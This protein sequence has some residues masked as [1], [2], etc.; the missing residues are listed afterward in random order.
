MANRRVAPRIA[1]RGSASVAIGEQLVAAETCD[2]SG[3]GLGFVTPRPI[4]PGRRCAVTF[5][6]PFAGG[7]RTVTA[8]VKVAHSTYLARERFQIGAGFAELGAE[9]AEA[10]RSFLSGG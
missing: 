3:E 8:M 6:L 5:T 7:E 4:S 10:I 9:A 2:I 1:L